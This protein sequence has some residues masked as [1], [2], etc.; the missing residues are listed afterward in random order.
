MKKETLK[1]LQEQAKKFFS[2]KTI[3][4][5]NLYER[6]NNASYLGL[7]DSLNVI[8]EMWNTNYEME[9]DT[10]YVY[11]KTPIDYMNWIIA[12]Y[13][14]HYIEDNHQ[15]WNAIRDEENL[16]TEKA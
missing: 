3:D 11:W 1:N 4:C 6:I 5:D 2:W 10:S 13:L 16:R 9:L 14:E 8:E 7:S 12:T 15:E